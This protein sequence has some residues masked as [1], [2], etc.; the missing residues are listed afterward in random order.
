[1][2]L[3]EGRTPEVEPS[4]MPA[5]IAAAI[6]GI[7]VA[8]FWAVIGVKGGAIPALVNFAVVFGTYKLVRKQQLD[9]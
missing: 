2:A 1:M 5:I 6:V 3:F 8:V 4:R 7:V 9:K